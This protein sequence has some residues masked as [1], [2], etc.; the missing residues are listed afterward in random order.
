LI[1]FPTG[2][3]EGRSFET[4]RKNAVAEVQFTGHW[5]LKLYFLPQKFNISCLFFNSNAI[6]AGKLKSQHIYILFESSYDEK[7]SSMLQ[8]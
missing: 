3:K 1:H 4:P 7:Y 6:D 5:C 8:K 2:I